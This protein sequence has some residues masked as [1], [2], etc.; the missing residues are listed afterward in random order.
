[1]TLFVVVYRVNDNCLH[2]YAKCPSTS[3]RKRK[4]KV[5]SRTGMTFLDG[6]SIVGKKKIK[7]KEMA[8]F[9]GR[10]LTNPLKTLALGLD[11]TV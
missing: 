7:K 6:I 9:P 2:D 11:P 10:I 5:P 1:M 3:F 8:K 4:S